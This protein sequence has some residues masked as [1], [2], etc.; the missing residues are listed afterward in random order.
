MKYLLSRFS[1]ARFPFTRFSFTRFSFTRFPFTRFPS[2]FSP[3]TPPRF[4][5]QSR[6][7]SRAPPVRQADVCLDIFFLHLYV[8]DR[9]AVLVAVGAQLRVYLYN[10]TW[11]G[12]LPQWMEG[13][14]RNRTPHPRAPLGR[15]AQ[16]AGEQCPPEIYGFTNFVFLQG[17]LVS[18]ERRR[19]LH[20]IF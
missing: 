13:L 8:H 5:C 15:I 14:A 19:D 6:S 18:S 3:A 9:L 2:L 7:R 17:G 11:L 20:S 12:F 1:C 10:K 16:R 4:L